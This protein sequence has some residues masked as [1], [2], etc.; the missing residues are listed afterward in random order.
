MAELEAEGVDS[1]DKQF[2][3]CMCSFANLGLVLTVHDVIW[4]APYLKTVYKVID[5]FRRNIKDKDL[6][7]IKK[8]YLR[9]IY[10]I[11][12]IT[13][14]LTTDYSLNTF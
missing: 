11:R 2:K 4:H 6:E 7:A 10:A 3:L 9:Y 12:C 13:N 8:S 1:N 5:E 14:C